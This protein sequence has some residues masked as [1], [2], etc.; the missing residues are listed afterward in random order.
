MQW[1]NCGCS[2]VQIF[3][4]YL[5][6]RATSCPQPLAAAVPGFGSVIVLLWV[7]RVGDI[8]QYLSLC[9]WPVHLGSCQLQMSHM[10]P[11]RP[12]RVPGPVPDCAASV[13]RYGCAPELASGGRGAGAG[14]PVLPVE[15]KCQHSG[16]LG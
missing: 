6:L 13:H 3:R 4:T 1:I 7:P 5:T 14:A 12:S 11:L 16:L 15:L 2:T 8:T 9:G 10:H